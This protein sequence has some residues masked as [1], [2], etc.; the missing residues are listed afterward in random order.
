MP[1]HLLNMRTVTSFLLF[2]PKPKFAS[3]WFFTNNSCLKW[4]CL[5]KWVRISA[6]YLVLFVKTIKWLNSNIYFLY[7]ILTIFLMNGTISDF[8]VQSPTTLLIITYLC[9]SSHHKCV[10]HLMSLESVSRDKEMSPPFLC[11]FFFPHYSV[12]VL[13]NSV[14]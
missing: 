3:Q 6:V 9:G 1:R 8:S 5:Q 13:L 2:F 4:N 12:L 11:P 10:S 7:S 14:V